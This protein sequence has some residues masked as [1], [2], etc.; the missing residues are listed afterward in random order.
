MTV[1]SVKYI[2]GET[3]KDESVRDLAGCEVDVVL[4]IRLE[5]R[6]LRD[7]VEHFDSF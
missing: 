5:R 6:Q 4:A 2:V 1:A 3:V 7:R